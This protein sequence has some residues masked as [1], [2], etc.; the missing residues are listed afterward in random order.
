MYSKIKS[1]VF[2]IIQVGKSLPSR[3]FDIFIIVMIILTLITV[4]A[5][6]FDIPSFLQDVFNKFEIVSI[7]VFTVEYLLRLW[8][9]DLLHP[10]LS[11]LRARLKYIASFMAIIDLLAILPFYLPFFIKIDLR[12]LRTMRVIRLLRVFKINRY[13]SALSTIAKVFKNKASQLV[14]SML[15][16]GLLMIIAS[17]L[18]Y[19]IESTV[20]PDKFAN[21]F[22]ALW[23]A[24]ATLT[25]VGYGD[26]Y[27]ITVAGKILSIII[28]I[29]GIGMVAVPTGIIT[30]GFSEVIN[31]QKSDKDD[32][33][34]C[35]YCGHKLDD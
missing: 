26:V 20:Q 27:P 8:T 3:I 21:A 31:K 25:T 10:E 19:N 28:A 5:E 7:F 22:D 14:S 11:S 24:I 6:T 4:I 9:A 35:P 18:M 30:A 16:V 17:I 2:E 33:K 1:R 13:T 15:V 32:K 23:W 29:L 34:F 12:V